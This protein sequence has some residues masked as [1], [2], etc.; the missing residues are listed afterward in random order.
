MSNNKAMLIIDMPDNCYE[1]PLCYDN[2]QC[3]VLEKGDLIYFDRAKA[4]TWYDLGI[5]LCK[6][7]LPH[8][9][10]VSTAI[11]GGITTEYPE[12]GND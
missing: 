11:L 10:L 7:R 1:C 2:I 9:P 8:C 4:E 5:D 6:Q 12:N 3:R